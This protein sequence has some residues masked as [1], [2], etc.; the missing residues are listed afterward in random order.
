MGNVPGVGVPW[1]ATP[2]ALWLL[3][4]LVVPALAAIILWW[5]GRPPRPATDR[6]SIDGH[7]Q[8]LDALGRVTRGG[9]NPD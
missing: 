4:P 6:E 2:W 7:R 5:R 3:A 9:D 8:Y 1:L